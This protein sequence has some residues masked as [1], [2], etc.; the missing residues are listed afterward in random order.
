LTG[1][2]TATPLTGG[3]AATPVSLAIVAAVA[4]NGVIGH[5]LAMPWRLP[6][7]LRRFRALTTGHTVIMGRRTWESLP[8]ALPGRQNIVVSSQRDLRLD[9]ALV[10]HSL[11]SA[12][13]AATL[14]APLFVIGGAVLYA[15]TLPRA[16]TLYLTEIAQAYAGDVLFPDYDR[17]PWQEAE[18]ETFPAEGGLPA[19]AFVRYERARNSIHDI[20]G[21]A[22]A[23]PPRVQA[24]R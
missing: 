9:G 11:D 2:N 19:Y 17:T 20:P 13:G 10:V 7:D 1:R 23:L 22:A 12:I 18:R 4:A 21:S 24:Q 14:P 3:N 5:G 8:H 6:A 15:A 16:A